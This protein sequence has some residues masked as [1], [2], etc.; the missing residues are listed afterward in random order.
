VKARPDSAKLNDC[1]GGLGVPG[2]ADHLALFPPIAT[3]SV[4]QAWASEDQRPIAKSSNTT[5]VHR[6]KCVAFIDRFRSEIV[7]VSVRP[8]W[9]SRR[10]R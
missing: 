4:E 8:S 6:L 3:P 5:G 7:N 2:D 1:I 10:N 9:H